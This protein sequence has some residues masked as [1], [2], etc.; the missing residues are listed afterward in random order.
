MP[1][2]FCD[3]VRARIKISFRDKTIIAG[4]LAL[5][6]LTLPLLADRVELKNGTVLTGPVIRQSRASIT[7]QTPTGPKT[8][9]KSVIRRIVFGKE[10]EKTEKPK[11]A[12]T[13]PAKP[14]EPPVERKSEVPANETKGRPMPKA[15]QRPVKPPVSRPGPPAAGGYGVDRFGLVARSAVLPGWGFAAGGDPQTGHRFMAIFAGA[16]AVTLYGR[17]LALRADTKYHE[18]VLLNDVLAARLPVAGT[19]DETLRRN[20][21]ASF[22]LNA[23]AYAPF[24]RATRNYNNLLV[25]D[26][27]FYL[28]QLAHC[29][30]ACGVSGPAAA[31]P[32]PVPGPAVVFAILPDFEQKGEIQSIAFLFAFPIGSW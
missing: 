30:F 1:G 8:I 3:Q 28:G 29:A 27:V 24:A 15:E 7:I 14:Q 6:F 22:Y 12:A 31:G 11:E 2:R 19:T 18:Q 23:S 26:L 5:V 4:L 16:A 13:E 17:E 21:V 25:A 9:P 20:L 10:A 32:T